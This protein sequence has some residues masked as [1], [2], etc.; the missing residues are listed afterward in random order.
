[1]KKIIFLLMFCLFVGLVY[2]WDCEH[3]SHSQNGLSV[4]S[5]IC[6]QVGADNG[7]VFVE[8]KCTGVRNKK[9]YLNINDGNGCC[10]QYGCA[11]CNGDYSGDREKVY[12]TPGQTEYKALCWSKREKK[13]TK[14][15]D[16][17]Y[18]WA[19]VSM[20]MNNLEYMSLGLLEGHVFDSCNNEVLGGAT[21]TIE[22]MRDYPKKSVS[23]DMTGYYSFNVP[24][25]KNYGMV[26][27]KS[28]YI[29]Y[30]KTYTEWVWVGSNGREFD[31]YLDSKSGCYEEPEDVMCASDV[32]M[33]A[34]GSYV[35]RN[36]SKNCE[37]SSCPILDDSETPIYDDPGTIP[38]PQPDKVGSWI[39]SFF[40]T[41]LNFLKGIF[42]F[43]TASL[44]DI[45][46]DYE[47]KSGGGGG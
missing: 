8:F 38:S 15:E 35:S 45:D 10:S 32:K 36:P 37:F 17:K 47:Y 26:V 28:G 9:L 23:T 13:A 4:Q 46:Y 20:T 1:M 29:D 5:N 34:D 31:V 41:I 14:Y 40:M 30:S 24:V 33:C 43:E 18:V 21:V 44:V 39:E 11:S 22:G 6:G 19:W 12:L 16:E 25:E 27:S 2:A 3:Y 7:G 42:G